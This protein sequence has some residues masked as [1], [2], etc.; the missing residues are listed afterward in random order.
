MER[1]T[2]R[3]SISTGI[4]RKSLEGNL[5]GGG[6]L[7]IQ[8]E[9]KHPKYTHMHTSC[10]SARQFREHTHCI[11]GVKL[12][13]MNKEGT[14]ALDHESPWCHAKRRS[15]VLCNTLAIIS[16][17]YWDLNEL[18]CKIQ[19][20]SYISSAP[21]PHVADDSH[22]GWHRSRTAYHDRSF[23]WPCW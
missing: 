6:S 16:G 9:R 3:S 17:G 19:F 15:T 22:I 1:L 4:C 14:L 23:T 7:G 10:S 11:L 13:L 21:Q 12:A 18:K 8:K 2:Q 5:Q 20:L